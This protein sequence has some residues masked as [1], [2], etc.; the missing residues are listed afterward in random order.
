MLGGGRSESPNTRVMNESHG[1]KRTDHGKREDKE[2][3]KACAHLKSRESL[4][5]CLRAPFYREMKGLLHSDITLES[6]EYS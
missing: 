3:P 2:S 5:T 1:Q 4:Y 6:K